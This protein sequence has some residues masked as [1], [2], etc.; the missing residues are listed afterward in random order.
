ML[1]GKVYRDRI[2]ARDGV[3][4]VIERIMTRLLGVEEINGHGICPTYL[5]R[6]TLGVFWGGRC[7]Y[8]PSCSQYALEAIRTHGALA[9]SWLGLR[10]I[11]RCHPWGGCGED[12]VPISRINSVRLPMGTNRNEF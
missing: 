4:A 10:R 11:C 7:K 6:W 5:Y 9:G 3:C 8:H 1:A 2:V 12:P